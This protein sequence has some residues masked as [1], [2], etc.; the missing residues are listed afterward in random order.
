MDS[1]LGTPPS[2]KRR[3]SV[4]LMSPGFKAFAAGL[5][6]SM[7]AQNVIDLTKKI[8]APVTRQYKSGQKIL[9]SYC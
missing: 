2:Q 8:M 4:P 5:S 1:G 7:Y 6:H 9:S 3:A